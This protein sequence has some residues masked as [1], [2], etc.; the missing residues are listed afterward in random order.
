[1][2]SAHIIGRYWA[3]ALLHLVVLFSAPIG[4][5]ILELKPARKVAVF[6]CGI[7][8]L[9]FASTMIV[10]ALTRRRPWIT[11][12]SRTLYTIFSAMLLLVAAVHADNTLHYGP[13]VV[14]TAEA[15]FQTDLVEAIGYIAVYSNPLSFVWGGIWM[16]FFVA[17][18]IFF[19]RAPTPTVISAPMIGIWLATLAGG[20]LSTIARSDSVQLLYRE[21]V[22]Y[23]TT[24]TE[25]QSS[26]QLIRDQL[27]DDLRSSFEGDLIVVIGESMSRHHMQLYG[28][29]RET[30]PRLSA[31][32][33][34]LIVFGDVIATHSHT[35][36]SLLDA[37]S[38][39]ARGKR[40]EAFAI[41]DIVSV[42][43]SADIS[44]YWV[45]N[46]NS[47]G[48]WDNL[49]SA[50]ARSADRSVFH[51]TQ[52]GT[53]MARDIYD[54]EMLPSLDAVLEEP[55][56]RK[57]VFVH[58]MAS[59]GPY[60]RNLPPA[61]RSPDG[62][63]FDLPADAAL[64]GNY[65][66]HRALGNRE[67]EEKFI[68]RLNCYDSSIRY[69]DEVLVDIFERLSQ[70]DR[71]ALVLF[72][73]DH[74]EAPLLGTGHESRLH[75]HFHVEIPLLLWANDAYRSERPGRWNSFSAGQDRPSS[76]IDLG[77]TIADL[78]EIDSLPDVALRSIVSPDF[79]PFVRTTLHESVGYDEWSPFSDP[80][81]IARINMLRLCRKWGREQ[82]DRLWAHRINSLGAL[83]EAREIFTGI[84][85]DVVFDAESGEFRV[86]HPPA[87]DVGLSF[88]TMLRVD[89]GKRR[90]W[91]D[92]KNPAEAVLPAAVDRLE[93]LN[94]RYGIKTRTI[95][96]I[97]LVT[98]ETSLVSNRGWH[99]SYYLPTE[100][101]LE[102]VGSGDAQK[103]KVLANELL[104]RI[105]LGSFDAISYDTRSRSYVDD[106]LRTALRE[107]TL[108]EYTWDL[109]SSI[110]S[111]ELGAI[112]VH[113]RDREVEV[114]LIRFDSPFDL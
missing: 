69:V 50:V 53:E 114:V 8:V 36:P 32:R 62:A 4:L 3:R 97:S 99:A 89:D 111:E 66:P 10:N 81:E 64:F 16:V 71:P 5:R 112:E 6:Y 95:V 22:H 56:Q 113:L 27:P 54:G 38:F 94:A 14:E 100:A 9:C 7:V 20:L 90:Y 77:F 33:D 52:G 31:R 42:A 28:Y 57:L 15:I 41:A 107:R 73:A 79:E 34:E 49:V 43:K 37:L 109:S 21:A 80:I 18:A 104:E 110:Q 83:L 67:K 47:V 70:R 25:Y 65:R 26:R 75:S 59:H 96:E 61:K 103:S 84:E 51:S 1:M 35:V 24:L 60:C 76:L 101:I 98:D 78:A 92:W 48:V 19:F 40:K 17:T 88:E 91:L 13:L 30:T 39:Q 85:I 12:L 93:A 105:D 58:F 45:S 108:S 63:L 23:H 11:S 29:P 44:T 74:G 72:F 86:Y 106:L 55:D 102:A 82:C 2:S 46:Q 68:R 87:P